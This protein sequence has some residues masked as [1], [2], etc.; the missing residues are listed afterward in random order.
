MCA[1]GLDQRPASSGVRWILRAE[2]LRHRLGELEPQ[3]ASRARSGARLRR[4]EHG[5]RTARPEPRHARRSADL[6]PRPC[7]RRDRD[8]AACRGARAERDDPPPPAWI[9]RPPTLTRSTGVEKR[10][11]SGWPRATRDVAVS[12]RGHRRLYRQF[13]DVLLP[14]DV[15]EPAGPLHDDADPH[16][17]AGRNRSAGNEAAVRHG[18]GKLDA[19]RRECAR[20]DQ[21]AR[22]AAGARAVPGQPDRR[23]ASRPTPSARRPR[24]PPPTS[25][26]RT[27]SVKENT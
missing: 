27:A 9:V 20:R 15:R 13:L 25:S 16:V 21:L 3:R 23:P 7:G 1:S 26:T 18:D 14:E 17:D 22:R 5:R 6:L 11:R 24:A 19:V 2:H 4:D 8:R 12:G 10:T